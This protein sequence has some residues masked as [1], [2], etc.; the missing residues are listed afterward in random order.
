[1][2]HRDAR[3]VSAAL[4]LFGIVAGYV[5]QRSAG[6]FQMGDTYLHFAIARWAWKH[7]AL[8]LDHW[9]K[10]VF[11]ALYALPSLG[12][13]AAAK[14]FT[15]VT[16]VVT[17]WFTY[18]VALRLDMPMAWSAPFMLLGSPIY[19]IHLNSTMTETT[20]SM[21]LVLGLYLSLTNRLKAGALVFSLLPFVR[22]EGF[23][24]LP[25]LSLWFVS[26][27]N[28][29]A[30]LLLGSGFV[31]FS[32]LGWLFHYH[33]P[34]WVF[35]HNPY[36][37]HS[38]YGS[39]S[40][41]HFLQSNKLIWG[42]VFSFLLLFSLVYYATRYRRPAEN[43]LLPEVLLVVMPAL[44]Y[45]IFHSV[46]WW[47]GLMGSAGEIRVIA[48]VMPLF[49]LMAC[50][51]LGQWKWPGTYA[52]T[53]V[54][55]A[56]TMLVALEPWRIFELPL[57]MRTEQRLIAGAAEFVREKFSAG[58]VWFID[59]YVPVVLDRDFFDAAQ[60]HQWFADAERPHAGMRAGDLVIWD[61]HFCPQEGHA[62]LH[63][64]EG[65]PYFETLLHLTPEK[66]QRVFG[67]AYEVYVFRRNTFEALP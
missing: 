14:L 36:H 17:A 41:T 12:G 28:W 53:A 22:T 37:W 16:G 30:V 7:P 59:P 64:F 27:R 55:A 67:L 45:L 3:G 6:T 25:L 54:A 18:R 40:L 35:R 26:R 47:L 2:K 13:Y 31:F 32:L 65:S 24:L 60:L 29:P 50:R 1:M 9:G 63:Y 46:A 4:L 23:V 15:L 61:A 33:D 5:F 52:G 49:A 38:E 44:V 62:P 20:F 34:L 21:V 11:T 10:P 57:P 66:E 39:G 58:T 8:F 19:F 42:N 43:F 48:A 51:A 56:L